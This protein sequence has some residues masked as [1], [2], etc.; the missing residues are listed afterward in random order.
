MQLEWRRIGEPCAFDGAQGMAWHDGALF[1]VDRGTLYRLTSDG[2]AQ[3]LGDAQWNT[4]QLVSA[5]GALL[6]FEE[7][8]GLY[9]VLPDGDWEPIAEAGAFVHL[10]AATALGDDS[11]AADGGSVYK[12]RA[13]FTEAEPVAEWPARLVAATGNVVAA[14]SDESLYLLDGTRLPVEL[15]DIHAVAG[16]QKRLWIQAG[17]GFYVVHPLEAMCENVESD[18]VWNTRFLV[19]GDALYALEDSGS[20]YALSTRALSRAQ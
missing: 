5:G 19:G 1:I 18:G 9:R 15:T 17:G 4:R 3:R 12:L 6:S 8:G 11:Y 7:T 13:P 20:L 10:H 16:W 2:D 14:V